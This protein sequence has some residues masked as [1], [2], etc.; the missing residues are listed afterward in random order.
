MKKTLLLVAMLVMALAFVT[1]CRGDDD[2]TATVT[3]PGADT[4]AP[5]AAGGDDAADPV[6]VTPADRGGPGIHEPVDF[7]G[8]AL[9]VGCWWD[10]ALNGAAMGWDEPDPAV[11]TNYFFDRL[12]W[13][14]AQRVH[15]EFNVVLENVTL[16]HEGMM[17]A[18][19]SSV[20]AGDAFADVVMLGGGMVLSALMGDL[21]M[22]LN[23]IN[24]PNSDLLG[25]GLYTQK[26]HPFRGE[27]WSFMCTRPYLGAMLMGV[28]LDI[29]NAIGAP[30][31]QELYNQGRWT[32]DAALDI[33]R[34]ATRDTTG[35]GVL[36][37]WG[38]AGQPGDIMFLFVGSNDGPLVT[39]DLQ[40]ALNH[41]NTMETL[42]FME[43]IFREGL[44]EYDP[45]LGIDTGDWGRNFWAFQDGNAA[46]W[47]AVTWGLNDGDLP[48]EFI[49]V[50]FPLGPSNTSGNST[51]GGWRQ[52]WTIPFSTAWAPEDTLMIVEEFFSW[53]GDEPGLKPES[54][55]GWPRGIWQTEECVQHALTAG[56]RMNRCIGM[57]VPQYNW[58][59]GT[60]VNNFANNEATPAQ[61]VETVTPAQQELIDNFFR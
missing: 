20:M 33:M 25:P 10:N 37:Q 26:L 12:M 11:S 53:P 21:I 22:P 59:F 39:D 15:A 57:V 5:P 60:F 3:T 9:R 4:P 40:V 44:W 6:D 34:T 47:P 46:F 16:D 43:I 52:S 8:R 24:L 45:V 1:A 31:P 32:W 17:P 38:I 36:D 61:A 51:L 23:S 19:T 54:E 58:I 14:N 35:D 28:N 56:T 2:E 27:Y 55:A 48:F 49:G 41:P 18:L 42:E 29:I 50:P 7:G 30:N 13:D